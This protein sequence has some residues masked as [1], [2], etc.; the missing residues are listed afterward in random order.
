M[1]ALSILALDD[2]L[3]VGCDVIIRI[4]VGVD[5]VELVASYGR[6]MNDVIS[7]VREFPVTDKRVLLVM[8]RLLLLFLMLLAAS[9]WHRRGFLPVV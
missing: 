7:L 5:D 3:A 4:N 2:C 6:M 1:R 9:R 8:R